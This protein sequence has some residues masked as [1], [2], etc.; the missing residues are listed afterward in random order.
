[1]PGT[2][3]AVASGSIVVVVLAPAAST[4]VIATGSM[5]GFAI[6]S[7]NGEC[8]ASRPHASCVAQVSPAGHAPPGSQRPANEPSPATHTSIAVSITAAVPYIEQSVPLGGPIT[9]IA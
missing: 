5:F 9:S 2:S 7:A 1:M 8:C 3:V 4:S 6:A